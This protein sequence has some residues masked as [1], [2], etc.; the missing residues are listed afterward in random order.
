MRSQTG[1]DTPLEKH[2]HPGPH[3]EG[4]ESRALIAGARTVSCGSTDLTP[5]PHIRPRAIT[6]NIY[7]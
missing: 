6:G 2:E 5:M 3:L 1:R 7:P 4:E